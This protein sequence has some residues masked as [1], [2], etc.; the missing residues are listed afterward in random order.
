MNQAHELYDGNYSFF[1]IRNGNVTLPK[2]EERVSAEEQFI[3]KQTS[4][5]ELIKKSVVQFAEQYP[6]A[7]IQII[8]STGDSYTH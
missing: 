4:D 1:D 3:F 2:H 8:N 6:D 7:K 5:F